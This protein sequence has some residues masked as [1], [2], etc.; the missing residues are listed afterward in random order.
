MIRENQAEH[1]EVI[2]GLPKNKYGFNY[3][4]Y[5]LQKSILD[6]KSDMN[7]IN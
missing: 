4:L 7:I 3:L 1:H 2:S 6:G 5:L